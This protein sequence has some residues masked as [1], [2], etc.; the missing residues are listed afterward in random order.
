MS[1]RFVSRYLLLAFVLCAALV[2]SGCGSDSGAST[3]GTG[4][5]K[6]AHLAELRPA[7]G[8][9]TSA[10]DAALPA[11]VDSM[12]VT[13]L[14]AAGKA[15]YGPIE[16][17]ADGAVTID[18]V[19]LTAVSVSVHYLRNGGY[20][21]ATDTEA[22]AWSG[23]TGLAQPTPAPAEA[24]TTRWN[25][26]VDAAGVAHI[27]NAIGNGASSDILLRGVAYS[28]API[29]FS[30]KDGPG[31]GD[32]F[33]DTPANFLDFERVWKRDIETIRSLG[34]NAVRT[35]SLI[36]HF[37]HDDGSIPAPEEFQQRASL[38]VREHKKF[39]DEAWNNGYN[40]IYVL[41]GI[42]MPAT[43]YYKDQNTPAN[44]QANQYWDDNFTA[45]VEQLK[46]HPAVIGFTLFN[47]V[48]G[49]PQYADNAEWAQY[50]WSQVQKY[51][52]RAKTIAPDKLV[53][54][55]FNDDPE[56]ARKTVQYR[57]QYAKS[58]DFYGV[59]AFQAKQLDSVLDPWTKS[60][61]GDAARPILLTEYGLPVTGHRI[62]DQ[63]TPYVEPE[64]TKARQLI[65]SREGVPLQDVQAPP[66][67]AGNGS[68]VRN[69]QA[70]TL[71]IYEDVSTVGK[72]ADAVRTL[73]PFA[74]RHPVMAGMFYFEWSDEWWKQDS[75]IDFQVQGRTVSLVNLF[76][77]RQEGGSLNSAFPNGFW[78]E[79][80]FGL[81]SIALD[82]RT[83]DQVYTDSVSGKGGNLQVDKLTP[84]TEL[85]N[86][87]VEAYRNAEQ[88]RRA[89]LGR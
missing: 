70:N 46:S 3:R 13:F 79:E 58:V 56:F 51:A 6:I 60:L 59:N 89:A 45:T 25:A 32:I 53:G 78:D 20:A 28:P 37:I 18:Q 64:L 2:M 24:S 40:P 48:G 38:L 81:H 7:S 21:L 50:Y 30:N 12:Q 67:L 54:W 39:L 80:G 61:Q 1:A 73:I 11:G 14:D 17:K 65:A 72:V 87:V 33:W 71:S 85:L 15:I 68:I 36:G 88:T 19:P 86:A 76:K 69:T 27:E 47:E 23:L 55:A 26:Y 82:G 8:G 10:A 63:F 9:L 83:A 34:F 22:I 5:V 57:L 84:R 44:A 35:Y 42:P 75:Y 41:V 66:G 4:S 29:G 52:D 74:F 16:V 43:I 77:S 62:G 49:Q 31:F